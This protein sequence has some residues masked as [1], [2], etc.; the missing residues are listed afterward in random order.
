MAVNLAPPDAASLLAIPGVDLGVAMAGIKKPN[1]KDLLVMRL[2][3]GA[4]V[5]GLFTQNRFLRRT[6]GARARAHRQ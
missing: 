3:P 2:A 5:A 6:R 1:R 4:S